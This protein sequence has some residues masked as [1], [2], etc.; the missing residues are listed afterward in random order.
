MVILLKASMERSCVHN[1]RQGRFHKLDI[2]SM[3]MVLL[4]YYRHYVTQRFI[5]AMFGDD[6]KQDLHKQKD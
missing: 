6:L 5:A 2:E 1:K 3:I 4:I